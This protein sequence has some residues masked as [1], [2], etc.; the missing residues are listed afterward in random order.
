MSRHY[1]QTDFEVT[2]VNYLLFAFPTGILM[3]GSSWL[4]LQFRYNYK[5]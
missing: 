5:E 4:W 2:F 3:L 1:S